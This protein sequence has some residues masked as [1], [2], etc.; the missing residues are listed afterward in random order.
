MRRVE[1]KLSDFQIFFIVII[2]IEKRMR[3][4]EIEIFQLR[5]I[6]LNKLTGGQIKHLYLQQP[7]AAKRI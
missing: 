5:I 6:A 7:S 4:T 2:Y 1:S 3:K